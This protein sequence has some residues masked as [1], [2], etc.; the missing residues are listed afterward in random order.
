MADPVQVLARLHPQSARL[1]QIIRRRNTQSVQEIC[2]TPYVQALRSLQE[3]I[4]T[5]EEALSAEVLCATMLL[6]L[7]EL[8]VNRDDCRWLTHAGGASRLIQLRGSSRHLETDFEKALFQVQLPLAVLKARTPRATD[9]TTLPCLP[10][11]DTPEWAR[12]IEAT[13]VPS[14]GPLYYFPTRARLYQMLLQLPRLRREILHVLESASAAAGDETTLDQDYVER[15]LRSLVDRWTE[16]RQIFSL[17][18]DHVT[19]WTQP[20]GTTSTYQDTNSTN[21]EQQY[22]EAEMFTALPK[23][24]GETSTIHLRPHQIHTYTTFNV[25]LHETNMELLCFQWDDELVLDSKHLA[26]ERVRASEY[27]ERNAPFLARSCPRF[28][29]PW[30]VQ[31]RIM[32]AALED[33]SRRSNSRSNSRMTFSHA[34]VDPEVWSRWISGSYY[35]GNVAIS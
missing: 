27:I 12:V 25:L 29:V 23:R 1:Q 21:N 28:T 34:W 35:C 18:I 26:N 22:T 32:T 14:N 3:A 4:T 8:M 2:R 20:A 5:P 9:A 16:A 7:Y 6:G 24:D 15:L 31:A 33:W 19:Q 30:T 11:L 10:Y 17:W 13:N